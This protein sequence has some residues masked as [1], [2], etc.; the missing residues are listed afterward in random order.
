MGLNSALTHTV[1]PR[2]TYLI[3]SL[4]AASL[5]FFIFTAATLYTI[6][7]KNKQQQQQVSE[8]TVQYSTEYLQNLTGTMKRL[9]QLPESN[10]EMATD[11]L[12]RDAALT[13]GVRDFLLVRDGMVY[14]SSATGEM[15]L[16]VED[17]FAGM[18]WHKSLDI[19]LE[20]GTSFIP[21]RP[22]IAVWYRNPDMS[23]SGILATIELTLSPYMLFAQT[24]EGY[25]GFAL[26]VGNRALTSIGRSLLDVK[27]L[28]RSHYNELK[29]GDYPFTLR[30]YAPQLTGENI[31]FTLLA[32]LLLS[33]M[34]GALLYFTL[35][36]RHSPEREIMQA[37]KHGQFFIEYQPVIETQSLKVAGMEALI[38]WQHPIEGR[39]PPD[40]FITF[41]ESQGMIV[42]LTQHMMQLVAQDAHQFKE[43]MPPKA[44]FSINISPHHMSKTSF[45]DDVMKFLQMLPEDYFQIVF[46]ITE[47]GM[48][49]NESA[50]RE[51][52]WLRQQGIEIAIDD[53]GTGHSALIYLEKF[54]L[55][56]LKIDRGFVMSIDQNTLIAPVLD[57][58]LK[59]TEEL[60][61]KTVAEGVETAQ[62]AKYLRKHGVTLLQ[63]FL[64]SKPLS[65][66]DLMLFTLKVNS[67]EIVPG[68]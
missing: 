23:D 26:I 5:L 24:D 11:Q 8:R 12:S 18:D 15:S 59:L 35:V 39:I 21:N 46:E 47:R 17:I 16:S 54:T 55:D 22:V 13:L 45:R 58:V 4:I 48:I 53:F 41:A 67:G 52:N 10:C 51:F 7:L 33:L 6:A 29:V 65:V 19:K 14:C 25:H 28:P 68:E 56:Y 37:L 50:M 62:Q 57:T 30:L 40:V 66:S 64:Y 43:V 38:R 3:R 34:V 49:D 63:G 60:N 20:Q 2:R 36:S 42:Q 44:K 1:L 32:S 61:L 27:D 31:R 9:S